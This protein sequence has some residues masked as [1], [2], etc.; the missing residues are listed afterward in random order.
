[1]YHKFNHEENI[2]QNFKYMYKK[3]DGVIYIYISDTSNR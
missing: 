3:E 2:G 1:M